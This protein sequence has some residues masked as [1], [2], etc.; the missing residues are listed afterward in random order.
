MEPDEKAGAQ[1]IELRDNTVEDKFELYVDGTPAGMLTYTVDNGLY[2]LHHE[3]ID[4]HFQGRGMG[5][6]LVSHA[7]EQIRASGS[8]VLPYCPFVQSYLQSHPEYLDLV[9]ATRRREFE[10]PVG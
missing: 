4:E 9:P 2:A 5:S 7:L 10:L 3:E 8:Q 1:D 6:Q